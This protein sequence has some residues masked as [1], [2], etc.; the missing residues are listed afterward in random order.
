VVPREPAPTLAELREHLRAAGMS[1]HH[2]PDRLHLVREMPLTANGKIQ[3]YVLADLLRGP[4]PW[5][6][7]PTTTSG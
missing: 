2:W 3:K 4:E 6:S 5:S 1:A 7:R